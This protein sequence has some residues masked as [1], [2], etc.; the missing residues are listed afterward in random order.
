MNYKKKDYIYF[1]FESFQ[2]KK[3]TDDENVILNAFRIHDESGSSHLDLKLY[4]F[5]N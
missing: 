3:G 1:N 4:Q 5:K 2:I